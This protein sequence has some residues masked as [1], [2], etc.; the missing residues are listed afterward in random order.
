MWIIV[1]TAMW[2]QRGNYALQFRLKGGGLGT[3]H[4]LP[5]PILP[6]KSTTITSNGLRF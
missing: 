4:R 1:N 3:R 5:S 2:T 6:R